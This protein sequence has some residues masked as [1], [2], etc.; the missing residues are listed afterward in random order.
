[1]NK[2]IVKVSLI[3]GASITMQSCFVAKNYE[4]PN[5]KAQEKFR[6]EVI[7]SDTT[8]IATVSWNNV[9]TDSQLQNY[10]NKGIQYNYDVQIAMQNVASAE[11]SMKKGKHGYYPTINATATWT[12]QETSKNSQFGRLFDRIDQYQL[13]PVISWEADIWGKIRSQKRATQASY[14]QTLATTK[15]VQAQ[16]VSSIASV[17]YQLLSLDA[18]LKVTEKTMDN[19]DESI[20]VAKALKGGGTVNEVGVI[21]TENQKIAT[22]I[23]IE[24]LKYNIKVLENSL[25]ILIGESPS[26]I[27]RTTIE[28]QK[29]ELDVTTGVPSTLLAN[30]PDLIAA[31]YSLK[32]T[33]EQTNIA[34]SNFYP[35]FT[36]TATT[37]FQ[38]LELDKLISAKSFFANIVTGLTQPILNARTVKTNFEIAKANQQKAFLQYEKTFLEATKEVSDAYASYEN[39]TKKLELRTQQVE[40]LNKAVEYSDKLLKYGMVNYLEVITAKDN[41]LSAELALIDNKYKQLNALITLY[42]SLGGGWQ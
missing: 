38:S 37:G 4:R 5:L 34:R 1:M 12:H 40:S 18:Q 26:T 33:F 8:S 10:I 35:S 15:A 41:A 20:K 3:I 25:S 9:F 11:A 13:S 29:I 16:I 31:E 42:R 30:R 21:Q 23:I 27:E 7:E 32:S 19:R 17:Y 36:I 28:D 22:Q 6:S 2:N 24:D 14:L 39:E